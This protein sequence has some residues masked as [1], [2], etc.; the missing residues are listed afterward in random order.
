MTNDE[1]GREG[2]LLAVPL[3][4]FICHSSFVI[5]H[6]QGG[7]VPELP[8]VETVRRILA[9]AAVGKRVVGAV[10]TRPKLVEAID[11]ELGI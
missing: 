1:P 7:T 6:S 3:R 9:R 11:T 10:C 4:G 5:R 8:E 2:R